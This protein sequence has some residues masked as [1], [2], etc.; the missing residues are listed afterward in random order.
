[1]NA[2]LESLAMWLVDFLVLST[3]LLALSLAA[4]VVI[5]QPGPRVALAWG[6][7][8]GIALIGLA[9]ALPA[10][11]RVALDDLVAAPPLPPAEFEVALQPEANLPPV[12]L[13]IDVVAHAAP[14]DVAPFEPLIMPEYEPLLIE[15]SSPLP[16]GQIAVA[17]WLASAVLG[18]I[19]ILAGLA[20]TG[21]LLAGAVKAPQ[22]VHAELVR[23]VS[24]RRLPGLWSS[25]RVG[26]AVALGAIKPQIVLPQTSIAESNAPAIRAALAHEW[27]HIRHGDLWLLALER[28]LLPLLAVHPLFW[29]LR[30]S[31]RLDQELLADA[32]AA[33][34]ERVEYAEALVAW[35]RSARPARHGLA[36]VGLWENPN[37]LSRRIAMILDSKRPLAGHVSRLWMAVIVLLLAPVVVGLSLVTLRPLA[38]Q[39]KPV[40]PPP[41][42]AAA[43]EVDAAAPPAVTRR[44]YREIG[45]VPKAATAVN[46]IQ[47]DL[48]VLQVDRQKLAAA[49]TTLEDEIAAAVESRCRREGGLIVSD[50]QPTEAATLLT[51]LK[52]HDALRIV[53]QPKVITLDGREAQVQI[54]GEAPI[55]R[56]EETVNGEAERRV[57]YR[58]FGTHL[59]V[60]P[61]LTGEKGELVTLHLVAVQSNLVP[62]AKSAEEG[63]VPRDVPGLVSHK[64]KLT[65]EVKVGGALLVAESPADKKQ[66]RDAV[67]HQMLLIVTPQRVVREVVDITADPAA[68]EAVNAATAAEPEEGTAAAALLK[69]ERDSRQ[70]ETA[71]LQKKIDQLSAELATLRAL[72]EPKPRR[73]ELKYYDAQKMADDLTA[74]I[75]GSEAKGRLKITVDPRLNSIQVQIED[76][77]AEGVERT[78]Q[79]LDRPDGPLDPNKPED[80]Y[81]QAVLKA[82]QQRRAERRAGSDSTAPPTGPA[83]TTAPAADLDEQVR[84]LDVEQAKLAVDKVE[85]ELAR[86]E[87][88]REKGAISQAEYDRIRI[89]V[90]QAKIALQR[91]IAL[92]QAPRAATQQGTADAD[93]HQ[94]P[95]QPN[96]ANW[97]IIMADIAEARLELERAEKE[98]ARAEQ[99]KAQKAISDVQV[100]AMKF[101]LEKARIKLQRA[102]AHM[103]AGTAAATQAAAQSAPTAATSKASREA[104]IRLLELDVAEAKTVLEVSEAELAH[105][106]EI[107]QKS[108]GAV[109]QQELR[110]YRAA[111][112]RGKIQVQRAEIKLEA[113]KEAGVGR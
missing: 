35:A 68:G 81:R 51:E 15:A 89:E 65:E 7:W 26:T 86:A 46:S 1:V 18:F 82:I 4:R 6:T 10:W 100:D 49:K 69:R 90:A 102:E 76:K 27:A 83:S 94:P 57:E 36:A 16:L 25:E 37:T 8:L 67:K 45:P 53:S 24:G 92:L 91:N 3:A 99:L 55:L 110:K 112:E 66:L 13:P 62:P 33:G 84:R 2:F 59:M 106:E 85:N 70:K 79:A 71:D 43:D 21:R 39:E 5:R 32:A 96:L 47:L 73:F 17:G 60:R 42:E 98:Y 38:A 12:E 63:A 11:P 50:I 64:F 101:D 56:V 107:I 54:G 48:T 103:T 111:V 88:L 72:T 77:Y 29:W 80:A 14:I 95:R 23:I 109:S 78:I 40:P 19:W 22:W 44:R 113:A 9:A 20:R 61:K 105:A 58:E 74:L 93:F 34:E 104:E 97:G 52:K 41:A 87:Q 31:V 108:L 28:T 30:R 75:S